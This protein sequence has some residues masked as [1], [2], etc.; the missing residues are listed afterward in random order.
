[1][2]TIHSGAAEGE[3]IESESGGLRGFPSTWC[4]IGGI[5][6]LRPRRVHFHFVTRTGLHAWIPVAGE[7]GRSSTLHHWCRI[8]IA[9]P[10]AARR[11]P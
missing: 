8:G 7:R 10:L 11:L 4:G 9:S 6:A 2:D 3:A 5:G 1:M